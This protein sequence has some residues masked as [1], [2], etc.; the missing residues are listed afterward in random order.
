MNQLVNRSS[1]RHKRQILVAALATGVLLVQSGC[2]I[3]CLRCA[4]PGPSLPQFYSPPE[5][6]NGST[7]NGYYD[8]VQ[9]G[10]TQPGETLNGNGVAGDQ[11][12]TLIAADAED[13]PTDSSDSS[14]RTPFRLA[15]FLRQAKEITLEKPVNTK[16][17]TSA[18][19]PVAQGPIAQGPIAQG[20]IAQGPIAQDPIAQDPIAQ[21]PIAQ[22]PIA[23]DPTKKTDDGPVAYVES[24]VAAGMIDSNVEMKSGASNEVG[25]QSS[26]DL[27]NGFENSAQFGWRAFF[28]DPYLLG[29][30]DQ[31]LVGNQELKILAEE[32]QIAG[33]ETYARSG[34]YRPIVTL[35]ASAGLEKSGRH[36]REG[37]V[38]EQLEV[39]SGRKFPDPLPNF[40]I[41]TN[42]S[43][44]L[45]IWKR[46]R[47]AQNAAAMRY[48]ASQEGR[49]YVVTR[50]IA[51]VAENYYELLALD[52]RLST[53]DKTIAIQEQ[54]LQTSEAM[55][56]NARGTELAVQRFQAEVRKNQS[57]KLIIQQ[58]IVEAENRINFL[59]GR[60]P[61]RVER[62]PVEFVDL[63]L[64]AL[65][66]GVPAQLLQNRPDIREAERELQAAGLDIQ[67]AR[68]RF[69]P[70]LNL[71]A[72]LGYEAFSAGYLFRT[73]ESLIYG[74]GGDLIAPLVN[75][76]AIQ[77]AYRTANARQLQAVY[78][79]QRTVLNA[80]T[81]VINQM[82][83]VDNYGKS[84]EIK[85]QQLAALEASVDT[86]T[87]LFQNV[88]AEYVEVLLAQRDMM[89]AKM[90]IIE[91]KQQQLTA[92]VYTFQALGGSGAQASF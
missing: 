53:L 74:I 77:A 69:Y 23:Q 50:L 8:A 5:A 46:L 92:V 41:G 40:L 4:Q 67:V 75:K 88:R 55:K 54:S 51:E 36:T 81:E 7:S 72:G 32:I 11:G 73:P 90:V 12:V 58:E 44:E 10:A 3:P 79:Y 57:E 60:Y 70:S 21:D 25:V 91:T 33:N 14:K 16:A 9:A 48:L 37:A 65:S 59:L 61:Q 64:R 45:D 76:R 83:K 26:F 85:K 82:T 31:A 52:N 1:T 6:S 66:V 28:E 78:D 15:G 42:V 20:P 68:A 87:K 71:S 18:Q 38:E 86:A 19:E 62:T 22:D 24:D 34:E 35:G 49:N 84:I 80:Y 29:L 27:A 17:G 63:N 43:W 47:N 30:I 56:I 39:A 2:G 89:E 13:K